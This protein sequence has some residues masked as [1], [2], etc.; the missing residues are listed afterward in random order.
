MDYI[1]IIAV[2]FPE[3]TPSY[4]LA[5]ASTYKSLSNKAETNNTVKEKMKYFI[6]PIIFIREDA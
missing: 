5:L 6:F 3:W 1:Y 4:N 2:N